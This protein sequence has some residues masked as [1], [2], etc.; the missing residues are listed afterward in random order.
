MDRPLV[1]GTR[2][3]PLAMAQARMTAGA[4]EVAHG[5]PEGSVVLRPVKTSG[6]RIQDR[7]LAEVGG[8]ALWT[9]ELDLA[10]LAGETDFSVHSMKDVESERPDSLCIVATLARADVRDRL[11]GAPSVEALGQGAKVGTSSPRRAAQ[12]L[13]LRPDLRVESIRGNVAT[14]LTRL[15]GGEY[16]ATLL[17]AAGLDRL[18]IEVG[19]PVEIGTMLPA[20]G[21]AAIG[22]ECRSD[23]ERTRGLLQAINHTPTHHAVTAERRFAR[24][25]GGSCHSPVAALAVEHGDGRV[26]LRAELLSSDGAE[27]VA[28]ELLFDLEPDEQA[29]ER[30]AAG[31]L[32]R[33]PAAVRSL[34]G[35]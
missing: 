13:R 25:I 22:I 17:A 5:W 2:G 4:L 6:D 27:H 3:S 34:F 12:L 15:Q 8:K 26:W 30:L 33:A 21:Q 16:D 7:P 1:L 35:G 20:P 9:K 31:L 32:E 14:R 19:T 24:A 29:P 11:I 28:G 18:G 23:D 10:L